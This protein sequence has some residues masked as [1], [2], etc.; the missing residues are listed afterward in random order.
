M[1]INPDLS[2]NNVG[3]EKIMIPNRN[4]VLS[5]IAGIIMGHIAQINAVYRGGP[6][7]H[8]YHRIM[9]LRRQYPCV[10]SF[11]SCDTCVE[12]LYATLVSWDMNSRGAKMKDYADFKSN[13]QGNSAAFQ[14][15][16][17]A[18]AA[19][20]WTNR[21][22]VIQSLST[23][24]DSLALMK[25]NGKLVSNSKCLHFVF[26]DLCPP[27]DRTNTLK[28]L[29]GN[30]GESKT[31]FLEVLD[32]S[33]DVIAGIQNP[34]QYLDTQWNTCATKLVDNAIIMLS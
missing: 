3:C 34:K 19:F 18:S 6:S 22:D 20:A 29:Y 1:R 33:Y 12:I 30:T 28:K 23:L 25:T 10:S 11:L 27:M 32:F 9:G 16:E 14:A 5:R 31:R 4:G 21:V 15:V 7:L 13:L 8:F 26:P 17:T 24:Y 2:G